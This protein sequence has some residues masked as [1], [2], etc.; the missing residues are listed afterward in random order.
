MFENLKCN[1]YD[2]KKSNFF[3]ADKANITQQY[4]LLSSLQMSKL[5]F[6]FLNQ[7]Q[8]LKKW[9]YINLSLQ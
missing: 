9:G 4:W 7:D 5:D 3:W 1:N 2:G 8:T 6:G